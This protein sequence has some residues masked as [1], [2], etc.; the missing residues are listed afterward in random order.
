MRQRTVYLVRH[1]RI[2]LP[3]DEKRFIGQTDIPL[4][5]TGVDQAR[6]LRDRLA[7]AGLTAVYC[8]D[9]VRSLRTAEII[10]EGYDIRIFSR[11]DLREI[12]LGAWDG[13]T[14]SDIKKRFPEEFTKRGLDIVHYRPPG[15]ESFEDCS[16]RVLAAFR[17]IVQASSGSILISGHAG[18]NRILLCYSMGVPLEQLF[19]IR[20]EYGQI[21]S[22]RV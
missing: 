16:K 6:R 8:S 18:V 12:H 19:T 21:S 11:K 9:L 22:L 7:N 1:G 17:E 2:Q 4:D 20:Q 14:F 15:G 3:D 5:E 13:C 10:T